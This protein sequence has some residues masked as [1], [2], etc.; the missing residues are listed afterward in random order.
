MD[1]HCFGRAAGWIPKAVGLNGETNTPKGIAAGASKARHF[2]M[3]I[4]FAN[5]LS[6]DEVREFKRL[7]E[8][9]LILI[10]DNDG[11][12]LVLPEEAKL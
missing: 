2:L 7:D 3:Q 4:N 12:P 11:D 5:A 1:I 9:L 8:Q 6:N 10:Q